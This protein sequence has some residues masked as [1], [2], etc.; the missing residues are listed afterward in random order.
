MS[1]I[2]SELTSKKRSFI[3]SKDKLK[4]EKDAICSKTIHNALKV[5]FEKDFDE[6]IAKIDSQI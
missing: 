2:R 1:K 4:K 6:H 3:D 5:S